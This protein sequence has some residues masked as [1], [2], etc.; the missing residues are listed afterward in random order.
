MSEIQGKK[1]REKTAVPMPEQKPEER[2]LNFNEVPY[3]YTEEQAIREAQRCYLCVAEKARCIP[4]CPVGIN[5][6]KFIGE[7]AKGD[8]QA[9]VQ[10]VMHDNLLPAICGRVC[11]QEEQCQLKC[12]AGVKGEP[13]FIGRLERF[14]A[15]WYA[16]QNKEEH[17]LEPAPGAPK[18]AVIGS[19]PAGLT[20]AADLAR[21]GYD[22]TVFEALHEPGGVLTYGIPEFRLPKAIIRR[23]VE[24]IECLGVKLYMNAIVGKLFTIEELMNEKGFQAVFIG[25]GAGL[26]I[27]VD[28][29]GKNLKGVYTANEFLTRINLMKAYLFPKYPTPLM[30]GRHVVVMGGGN[31]AMDSARTAL[32]MGA[33]KVTILY[34]RTEKEMPAR[35]EEVHHAKEEGIDLQ[36]LVNPI[37]LLGDKDGKLTTVESRRMELGAP[38]SSGRPRPIDIPGSEFQLEVDNF[39]FAIGQGPNPVLAQSTPGLKVDKWGRIIVDPETRATSIPG[40]FSGGDITGG[41]TVITAM[42]DGRV[43]ARSIDH[44]LKEKV[45]AQ[46]IS[47]R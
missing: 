41:A 39:V 18:V 2:I 42:G 44:Y 31:V 30:L 19:G 12:I 28:I 13:I 7:I 10:T 1:G 23:E 22:V 24:N 43:A 29:P 38:D 46:V 4:T 27:I 26:P 16:L 25:T 35:V 3:G 15:D 47:D 14:I 32:R 45:T 11:P 21:I 6:P 20:C 8:F 40:V 34:R 33:E 36:V 17:R 5:I 37:R 9:A